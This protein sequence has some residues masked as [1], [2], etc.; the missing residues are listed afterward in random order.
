MIAFEA[1]TYQPETARPDGEEITEI[2]WFDRAALLDATRTGEVLLPPP[3]SVA[4]AM[5][6]RWYEE[7]PGQSLTTKDA[8]RS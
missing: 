3:I 8:W 4:R 1:V 5:I 6:D 2:R 7:V